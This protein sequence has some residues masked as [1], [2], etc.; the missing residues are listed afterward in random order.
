[1]TA[2]WEWKVLVCSAVVAHANAA[3]LQGVVLSTSPAGGSIINAFVNASEAG[4]TPTTQ[5]TPASGRFQLQCPGDEPGIMVSV[6]ARQFIGKSVLFSGGSIV[7]QPRPMPGFPASDWSFEGWV[8][9]AHT[10]NVPGTAISFLAHPS[11]YRTPSGRVFMTTTANSHAGPGWTQG[12]WQEPNSTV[13]IACEERL[14]SAG[15][16][17]IKGTPFTGRML[18]I[19]GRLL[20]LIGMAHGTAN[21]VAIL[22]NKNLHD[23]SRPE[24]W[25]AAEGDGLIRVDWAGSPT[26]SHE[27]YRLHSFADGEDPMLCN[28]TQRKYWLFVIPDD[29]PGVK[30]RACGRL[31]FASDALLGPYE[32]CGYVIDPRHAQ[33]RTWPLSDCQSWPGDIIRGSDALYFACGWGL[34]YKRSLSLGTID[35]QTLTTLALN[36]KSGETEFVRLS[37]NPVLA[38]PFVPGSYDDIHQIEYTFLPPATGEKRW[39]LYHASYSQENGNPNATRADYG[40]KQAIGM[41]MFDWEA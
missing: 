13:A 36:S 37:E 34:I 32:Y 9:E 21:T 35:N 38:E 1:M 19:D 20:M 28:G 10:R 12:Y 22:E 11:V 39:R 23:P 2:S 16:P 33:G 18:V 8:L 31:G 24:D 40:Y 5:I 30:G 6:A 29:L 14:I 41:Y 7:L 26:T 25:V 4:C 27:D 3:T 15:H 17:V